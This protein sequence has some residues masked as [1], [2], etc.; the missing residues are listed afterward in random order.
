MNFLNH[1]SASVFLFILLLTASMMPVLAAGNIERTY[2]IKPPSTVSRPYS[3]INTE[4]RLLSGHNQ[5]LYVSV[6]QSLVNYYGNLTHSISDNSDYAGF[7]TP[8]VVAPIADALLKVT[9]NLPNANEQFAD[10]VL[11]FV[12]QITY[13]I[14]NPQY[15]VETLANN[16]GDCVGLSLLAA[17]IMEAGGLDVVLILYTGINP[18]HMNVGVYLPYT[19]IYHTPLMTPT[20]FIYDNKSYWTA[21]ATPEANWKV[22]DQSSALA[23][24]TANIIPLGDAAQS[25]SLPPAQV[26]ASLNTNLVPST[27]TVNPSQQPTS[28]DLNGERSLTISGSITPGIPSQTVT[29]YVSSSSYTGEVLNFF[30]TETDIYGNYSLSWNFTATGTY[31]ITA[32]W[33]GA[34]NYAGAD[35]QT[36]PVFVGPQSYY[37]FSSIDYN[38]IFGQ[39]GLAAFA[40][41]PMQGANNF[42]TLPLG[43]N[44]SISYSFIVLPAGQTISNVPTTNISV[45]ASIERVL[46][47][48]GGVNTLIV[49]AHNETVPASVPNGLA[50]LMLPDDFNQTLDNQF[51]LILQNNADNYSLNI[52][53]LSQEDLSNLQGNAAISNVTDDIK[54]NVWYQVTTKVSGDIATTNLSYENGTIIS[55]P[56]NQNSNLAVLLI[57][58]NEDAAVAL[59]NLTIQTQNLNTQQPLTTQK[60]TGEHDNSIL[61][62]YIVIAILAVA[63]IVATLY[64]KKARK[65]MTAQT[66]QARS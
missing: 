60:P 4:P 48:R 29:I 63:T 14:T 3:I 16:M 12:H 35:S 62:L 66:N 47:F 7:V 27:I 44:A 22:G 1:K 43:M 34:S 5:K 36:L 28:S 21:E 61:A 10:A 40:T 59:K 6:P 30:T 65:E 19:P 23:S 57:T 53:G 17:S 13:N 33:N 39:P 56:N 18:Q 26:S 41:I 42:L 51:S 54:Q 2:T 20:S 24:A 11:G 52:K 50:P 46:T 37:Q 58:N 31:Y 8:Q 49:P 55:N 25:Q 38:Y 45:P 9:D 32:N 64:V 15:P